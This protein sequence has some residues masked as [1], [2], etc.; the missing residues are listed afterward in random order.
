M[1]ARVHI[2]DVIIF[3][4]AKLKSNIILKNNFSKMGQV[5]INKN[6]LSFIQEVIIW[7]IGRR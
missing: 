2:K 1:F 5:K 4:A 3:I 6:M 7:I